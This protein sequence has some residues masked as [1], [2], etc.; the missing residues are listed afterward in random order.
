M[1][2]VRMAQTVEPEPGEAAANDGPLERLPRGVG[3]QREAVDRGAPVVPRLVERAQ[4]RT[5]ALVA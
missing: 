3:M 4:D 5:S 1:R 2:A